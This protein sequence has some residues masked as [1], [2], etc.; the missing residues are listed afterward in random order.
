MKQVLPQKVAS[1]VLNPFTRDSRVEKEAEALTVG[2][3]AVTVFAL[4]R[5]DL[6]RDEKRSGYFVERLPVFARFLGSSFFAHAVKTIEFSLRLAWRLRRF[7]FVHCHDF[8]PLP[9]ALLVRLTRMSKAKIVYDAHE[10]E[11]RKNGLTP[12]RASC[13][14]FLEKFS[15]RYLESLISV[16][17][18]ILEAYTEILPDVRGTLILNCPK[19]WDSRKKDTLRLEL[20][21][22]QGVRVILYQGGFMPGRHIEQLL[23]AFRS[24]K[25]LDKAIVFLG[26]AADTPKARL[27]EQKIKDAAHLPNVH[28]LSSVTPDLLPDYTVSADVGIC[29]IEDICLSYRYCLPNKFFEFAMAGLPLVVSDLPEMKRMVEEYDCGVICRSSRPESILS[30]VDEVLSGDH[31]G[32]GSNARRMAE[33]HCWEKQEEKLLELYDSMQEVA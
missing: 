18:A 17:P 30:A 26:H 24:E 2:G 1:V 33:D 31:K 20:G 8:H 25:R 15:S 28:Y 21:I 6:P 32:L 4:S 14:R 16:S 11:S 23:S 27:L 13:V 12:F 3:Y 10:F 29:L 19:M 22:P 5:K 7:D 9:A